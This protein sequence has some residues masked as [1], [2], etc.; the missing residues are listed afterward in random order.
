MKKL[1][2]TYA[3]FLFLAALALAALFAC[4]MRVGDFTGETSD[5]SEGLGAVFA[6]ILTIVPAI[7]A[8]PVA[9]SLAVIAIC[10]VA[11]KK[12]RGSAVAALVILSVFLPLLGFTVLVD[13]DVF[14]S[15]SALFAGIL[16][17]CAVLYVIA[18]ILA[19]VYVV[20]LKKEEKRG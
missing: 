4:T 20:A 12:Q 1:K 5:L 3:V 7:A 9:F 15:R 2:G 19:I 16:A 8:L 13:I 17:A 6:V 14:A 11:R 10:L 18:F